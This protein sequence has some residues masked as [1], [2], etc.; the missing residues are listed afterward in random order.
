LPPL[1]L[2]PAS[3]DISMTKLV[4]NNNCFMGLIPLQSLKPLHHLVFS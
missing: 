2:Q 1:L 3:I 4:P